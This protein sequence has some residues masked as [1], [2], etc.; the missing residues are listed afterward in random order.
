MLVGINNTGTISQ[1]YWDTDSSG[2]TVA[3]ASGISGGTIALSSGTRSQLSTYAGWDISAQGGT[4]N[5]WRIY[6]GH[7]TTAAQLFA[8]HH[9][10]RPGYASYL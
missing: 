5:V 2:M 3:V 1:S 4:S 9:G 8:S 6:E 10:H 7:T